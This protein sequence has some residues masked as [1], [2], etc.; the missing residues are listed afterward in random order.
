[1]EFL[2]KHSKPQNSQYEM[3]LIH[4]FSQA[5]PLLYYLEED[6]IS[7][8]ETSNTIYNQVL[9]KYNT[10]EEEKWLQKYIKIIKTSNFRY[11]ISK[12]KIGVQINLSFGLFYSRATLIKKK[13]KSILLYINNHGKLKVPFSKI[14]AMKNWYYVLYIYIKDD[15]EHKYCENTERKHVHRCKLCSSH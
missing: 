2:K 6:I 11:K 5:Y 12:I 9:L 8:S 1:M 10:T 15:W 14:E 7:L 13:K 3:N 4:I